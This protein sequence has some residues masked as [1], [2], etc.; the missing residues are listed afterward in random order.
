MR[1]KRYEHQACPQ[2]RCRVGYPCLRREEIAAEASGRGQDEA[3]AE[4]EAVFCRA[5]RNPD[6]D[7]DPLQ[8]HAAAGDHTSVGTGHQPASLQASFGQI[9]P[10]PD[11]REAASTKWSQEAP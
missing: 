9:E 7:H 8:L 2:A 4:D 10:R 1:A 3:K 11:D 6:G 5:G